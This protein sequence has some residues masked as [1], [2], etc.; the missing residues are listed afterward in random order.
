MK[1]FILTALAY[2][3]SSFIFG[4]V[5]HLLFFPGQY[6]AF[7]IFS[8]TA[9]PDFLYILIGTVLESVSFAYLFYRFYDGMSSPFVFGVKIGVCLFLFASSYGVYQL[10]GVEKIEGSGAIGFIGLEF[11][12]MILAGIISG[13]AG[14]LVNR[15]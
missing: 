1:K 8:N 9:N 13:L 14:G 4:Y 5:W 15:K 12:Y 3:I 6:A 10:A 2:F 7:K 11:T